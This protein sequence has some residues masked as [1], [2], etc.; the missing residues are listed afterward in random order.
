MDELCMVVAAGTGRK[1]ADGAEMLEAWCSALDRN[2][3][4]LSK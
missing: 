1:V 3:T 4:V 2:T